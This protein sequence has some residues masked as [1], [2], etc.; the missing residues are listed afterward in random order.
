MIEP[1]TTSHVPGN[2]RF[3]PWIPVCLSVL[4]RILLL[5]FVLHASGLGGIYT[6][7]TPNYIDP[8][9]ALLHGSFAVHS[10]PDVIRTPGYPLFLLIA[11]FGKV[12]PLLWILWQIVISA[13]SVAL[14]YRAAFSLFASPKT[15]FVCALLYA[16]EPGSV[17]CSI[18]LIADA[19]LACFLIVFIYFLLKYLRSSNWA[20]LLFASCVLGVCTYIKP[21]TYYLPLC[22]ACVLLFV[23]RTLKTWQRIC[24]AVS[25]FVLF[26][27]LVGAWQLRN[28]RETGYSGFSSISEIQL[29]YFDYVGVE[30]KLH[31]TDFYA[32]QLAFGYINPEQYRALHPDQALW[33]LDRNLAYMRST[34]LSTLAHHPFLFAKLQLRGVAVVILDPRGIDTL[35]HLNMYPT[36]VNSG[37]M[38]MVVNRGIPRTL[39]WVSR[40]KRVLFYTTVCLGAILLFY[41]GMALI[42]IPNVYRT[43]DAFWVLI[44]IAAYLLFVAG[45]PAASGRYRDPVMPIVCLFA[46][47][48]LSRIWEKVSGSAGKR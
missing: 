1:Q 36:G 12:H 25:F 30:A 46:G 38:S 18:L 14:L 40:N 23:P 27:I 42:G 4:V 21:V 48:G 2:R 32:T 31:H 5:I 11:G 37:L 33:S 47:A 43:R 22:I 3:G 44:V 34:A 6:L 28:Y 10:V 13:L 16:V 20:A 9:A 8:I 35:R 39:L 19:L 15:A 26:A 7:D 17:L 41:Y 24:R 29:Y 45:G